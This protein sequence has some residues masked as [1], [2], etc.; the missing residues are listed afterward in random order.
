M[1]VA[2]GMKHLDINCLRHT[3]GPFERF[4]DCWQCAAVMQR[5]EVTLM[6]GCNG[7]GNVVVA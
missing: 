3:R 2:T 7:G 4:V 5:E 6:P 1:T